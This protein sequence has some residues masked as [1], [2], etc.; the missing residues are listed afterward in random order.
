MAKLEGGFYFT[1]TLGELTAYKMKGVDKI[2]LRHKGGASKRKIKTSPRFART[3]ENYSEFSG[4]STAASLLRRAMGFAHTFSDHNLLNS[5]HPLMRRIQLLDETSSRGQRN[6]CLHVAPH[7]L[8]GFSLNR[9]TQFDSVVRSSVQCSIDHETLSATVELPA[10][11]P[12]INFFPHRP[13][14]MFQMLVVLGL[15]PGVYYRKTGFTAPREFD[16]HHRKEQSTEWQFAEKGCAAQTLQ[17]QLPPAPPG[18]FTLLVTVGICFG[19]IKEGGLVQQ[20][21]YS[22]LAK[23]VGVG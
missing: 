23:V 3:R 8:Q 20:E 11:V 14:P 4:R 10:L 2:V 7:L 16:P 17:L 19:S 15:M 13:Y 9:H 5:L 6:I 18:D 22:G 1:G 12:K 21:R